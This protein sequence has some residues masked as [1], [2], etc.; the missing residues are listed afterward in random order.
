MR[1]S[2]RALILWE[3]LT[4][5]LRSILP[6][7]TMI[8]AL[9]GC[10]ASL[11]PAASAAAPATGWV[12]CAN[13]S[14]G[15]PAVDIYLLAFGNSGN[16]TVLRHVSYGDVSSYMAVSAGQYTVAMRPVG[17]S[18]SSPP[19]VS[20]NFMVSAGTNYTVASLGPAS[21]RRIE[22]LRDQMA[23][24]KGSALIRV[25]QASLKQDQVTVSYGGD[26]LAQQLAF[27]GVTS[28]M[29]VRPGIQTVKF[30]ASGQQTTMS[31]T[32]AAGSVHTIVVLDSSSG[33]KVDNLTDAAGSSDVPMGGAATGFGGMA[34]RAAPGS[35]PWLAALV[36][37]LL[38]MAAGVFGLRR[39]RRTAAVLR[40]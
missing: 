15:N 40:E 32:L 5:R 1:V 14:P 17:A 3:E 9:L 11:A 38:L 31:V 37:G 34:P 21:A 2:C 36:A 22:V 8:S 24:P 4:V 18:A 28:Y 19:I 23:A 25:I 20:A 16:P 27:G 39:S 6:L 33:L 12:R 26:V 30:S 29:S 10:A 35:A 13:L 7:F